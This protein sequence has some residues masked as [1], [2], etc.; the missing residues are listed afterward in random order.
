MGPIP[1]GSNF[2]K[3]TTA[4]LLNCIRALGGYTISTSHEN[5]FDTEDFVE[6][7]YYE[8]LVSQGRMPPITS[9]WYEFGDSQSSFASLLFIRYDGFKVVAYFCLGYVKEAAERGFFVYETRNL[10]PKYPLLSAFGCYNA[11]NK[12]QSQTQ[13]IHTIFSLSSIDRLYS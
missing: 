1:R 10:H 7:E 13:P 8:N 12:T 3:L 4:G 5:L 6:P 2:L 11:T 9:N